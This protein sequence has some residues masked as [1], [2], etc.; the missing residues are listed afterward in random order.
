MEERRA[1]YDEEGSS[2]RPGAQ[3]GR[4]GNGGGGWGGVS[5]E[6]VGIVSVSRAPCLGRFRG[7]PMGAN[8]IFWDPPILTQGV[9]LVGPHCRRTN[10]LVFAGP[11]TMFL[12]KMAPNE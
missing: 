6:W 8:A 10:P 2:M 5:G 11:L 12:F 7:K 3:V 9:S 4:R 1:D